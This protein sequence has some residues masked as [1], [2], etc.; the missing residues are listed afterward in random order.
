MKPPTTMAATTAMPAP[1]V[2]VTM[3][4]KMLPRMA[5]GMMKAHSASLKV[6]QTSESWKAAS[7]GKLYL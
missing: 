4:P 7:F 1:S 2:A 5:I 3:P 6:R